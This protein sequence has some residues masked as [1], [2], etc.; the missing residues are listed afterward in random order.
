[1][2][3]LWCGAHQNGTSVLAVEQW[4]QNASIRLSTFATNHEREWKFGVML[5]AMAEEL[6]DVEHI[7]L[8]TALTTLRATLE[9]QLK[10]LSQGVRPVDLDE[11]I[12]RLSRMDAMQ[13]QKMAIASR[14]S[15]RQRFDRVVAALAAHARDEYGECLHCDEPIGYKRLCARP[16]TALCLAC[17]SAKE[18][19]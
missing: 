16:E 7:A 9:E 5:A 11:P 1:M 8:L 15:A 14:R 10:D 12:G 3:T 18:K 19:H 4:G 2:V 17:Q 13:Q 6:T